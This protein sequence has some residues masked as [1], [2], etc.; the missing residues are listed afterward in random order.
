MCFRIR[1]LIPP[2][3]KV[4]L[5]LLLVDEM[6][7]KQN[8]DFLAFEIYNALLAASLGEQSEVCRCNSFIII[9]YDTN[10]YCTTDSDAALLWFSALHINLLPAI[11]T[12]EFTT[13]LSI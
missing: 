3:S 12:H 5:L 13:N 11:S 10:H 4:F 6:K 1:K 2:Q 7:L 8:Q 9:K